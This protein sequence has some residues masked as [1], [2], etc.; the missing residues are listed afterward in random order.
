M[1]FFFEPVARA[2]AATPVTAAPLN[3]KTSRRLSRTSDCVIAVSFLMF[4]NVGRDRSVAV[5]Q[6]LHADVL[7]GGI[8][9]NIVEVGHEDLEPGL[10]RE[11]SIAIH[12]LPLVVCQIEIEPGVVGSIDHDEIDVTDRKS[13]RLNSSH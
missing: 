1:M 9:R 3:F 6:P 12:E 7:V 5:L 2:L 4:G 8:M 13:T 11:A 10:R